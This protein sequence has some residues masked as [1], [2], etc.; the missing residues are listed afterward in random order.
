MKPENISLKNI[1]IISTISNSK[2]TTV[3]L[4]SLSETKQ[5]AVLKQY[6]DRQALGCYEQASSLQSEYLPRIY[7]IWEEKDATFLL[8][9]YISGVTLQ[10]KLEDETPF[11]EI[12]LTNLAKQICQA[13]LVLHSAV[14]P[15]IHRDIKPENIII[16]TEGNIKL[17]DFDAARE[18]SVEKEHDTILMGTKQYASPEQFGFMQTDTRS[19]IY[20]FGIVFSELL[21]HANVSE[22]YASK[23]KKIINKATMFD[24]ENR[25]PDTNHLL[26]D[27]T[28][29]EKRKNNFLLWYILAGIVCLLVAT[30]LFAKFTNRTPGDDS[31][32]VSNPVENLETTLPPNLPTEEIIEQE[33]IESSNEISDI[34]E[35]ETIEQ[36]T[37]QQTT[38]V[39]PLD[40]YSKE[41][42]TLAEVYNDVDILNEVDPTAFYLMDKKSYLYNGI[43]T[44]CL[45]EGMYSSTQECIIG[46]DYAACRFLKGYPRDLVFCDFRL[47]D[48]IDVYLYPYLE[49]SGENGEKISL[50]SE[51][52]TQKFDNVVSVSKD[53]LQTLEPGAYTLYI[54][55][56][57][58]YFPLYLIVH[59]PEEEVDK[60]YPRPITEVGYYSS[61]K[62][63]DVVF[64]STGTP[65]PIK[66]VRMYN[67]MLDPKNYTLVDGGYG[68]VFKPDFLEQWKDLE[69]IEL[70]YVTEN[71]REGGIRIINI[72]NFQ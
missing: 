43:P 2:K 55:T 14:P 36:N 66:E 46:S 23:A 17:L 27:L 44:S 11:S 9:E 69:A 5:F 18:Y 54:K 25:Y 71:D 1:E 12:E 4:V 65:Y 60:F 48:V 34:K 63:N 40:D 72:S 20:S 56:P 67:N 33:V 37:E 3:K 21:S 24:P 16:T 30:V 28:L 68:I 7:H 13:L 51:D 22:N 57:N 58:Y 61:N 52:Y 38:P 32:L 15:I 49:E 47:K 31:S 10:E 29:L 19:D 35:H 26:K 6:P 62:Q 41:T 45:P 70:I 50:T 8:E 64:Y 42:P 59:S 53:F 39:E